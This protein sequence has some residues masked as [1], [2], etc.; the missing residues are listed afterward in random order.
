MS[1]P[2]GI[3]MRMKEATQAALANYNH[4]S[5]ALENAKII[6]RLAEIES[7]H[8]PLGSLLGVG[9]SEREKLIAAAYYVVHGRI[10]T[11]I[12]SKYDELERGKA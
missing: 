9:V 4:A 2:F 5:V 7:Q 12:R 10:P 3:Y 8:E 11:E 6:E 1:E